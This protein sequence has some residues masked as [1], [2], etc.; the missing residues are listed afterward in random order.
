MHILY[1]VP[2]APNLIR[3]RPYQLIRALLRRGHRVT[4][5]TLWTSAQ[6]VADLQQLAAAGAH[7]V[8]Q[9]QPLW[10]SLMNSLQALPTP[11]PLQ[12]VY[13]WQPTLAHTLVTAIQDQQF[14][15]VHV[16]HLRGVRYGLHLQAWSMAHQMPLPVVWDS[17][18]CISHLFAQAAH[19]SRSRTG[20]LMTRLE[21]NRTR[22]YEGWLVHQ[23]S[24]VLVTSAADQ[25]AMA[26]LALQQKCAASTPDS[27]AE[28]ERLRVLP[29]GVDLEYFSPNEKRRDAMTIVFSGKMSYHAN[30]TAALYLLE[31]IM[32]LVWAEQPAVQL[33]IVGKDPTPE[34]RARAAQA[35]AHA[36]TPSVVVTGTVADL[37]PYLH[38]AT[39]AVAPL[40]Y[41]TGIQN[42]VL[43]A[44]AC[45]APVIASPQAV[46]ALA[47]QPGREVLV[48]E[49]AASFAQAILYLLADPEQRHT[50]GQAGRTYVERHHSWDAM[51]AQLETIYGAAHDAREKIR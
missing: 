37:R 33:Y 30:V 12:A 10:R 43:E 27:R 45:G 47:I 11:T 3:V 4:V 1:I 42:K 39:V 36:D 7:I 48:A 31:E 15:V 44:M 32:P 2:Y 16:E 8:A 14:D 35:A 13:S 38:S 17:V 40:L 41:S 19:R 5:A 50:L 25:Q 49:D 6:D 22:S 20:R 34:I 21:L 24:Q 51:A 46:A 23:F 29:N 26:Q 28:N 9:P 18:D